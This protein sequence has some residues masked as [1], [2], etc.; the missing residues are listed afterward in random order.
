MSYKPSS[1]CTKLIKK[2]I[3]CKLSAYK[4]MGQL[5]I[6]YRTD[7]NF[8]NE[9]TTMK[10]NDKTSLKNEEEATKLLEEV[11]NKKY[12]PFTVNLLNNT[13]LKFNQNEFDALLAYNYIYGTVNEVLENNKDKTAIANF[14]LI[15]GQKWEE[16]KK[17]GIGN[18]QD[19]VSYGKEIRETIKNLFEGK[20]F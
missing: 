3:P 2:F 11:L 1:N 15:K 5:K 8:A 17:E 10:I 9:V 7:A 4:F 14:I 12:T 16:V 19:I 6:G 20:S 13:G 18:T